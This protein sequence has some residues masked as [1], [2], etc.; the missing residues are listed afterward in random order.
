MCEHRSLVILWVW[1][2]CS[3]EDTPTSTWYIF[4]DFAKRQR[5]V[6]KLLS[7]AQRREEAH[8]CNGV[9]RS[10]YLRVQ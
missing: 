8:S 3:H 7:E 5:N 4:V 2:L 9:S 10:E 6:G 1:S